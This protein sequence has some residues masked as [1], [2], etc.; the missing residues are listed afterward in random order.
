MRWEKK[1]STATRFVESVFADSVCQH[2]TATEQ[3][4]PAKAII[5]N[6]EY[7]KWQ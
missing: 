4:N 2:P 3:L 7:T 6:S 5:L 1:N